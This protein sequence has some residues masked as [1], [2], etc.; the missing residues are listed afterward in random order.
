MARGTKT[1][2][3]IDCKRIFI[4]EAGYDTYCDECM[5]SAMNEALSSDDESTPP[6]SSDEKAVD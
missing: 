2:K 3:C 5:I 4:I 6:A 1:A